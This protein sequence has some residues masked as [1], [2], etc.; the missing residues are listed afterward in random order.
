MK[1]QRSGNIVNTGSIYSHV[2]GSHKADYNVSKVAIDQLTKN[3]ALELARSLGGSSQF[4]MSW[5]FRD[6]DQRKGVCDRARPSLYKA[7]RAAADG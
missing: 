7:A 3:M 6:G 5:L 4:S 2:S 1:Q